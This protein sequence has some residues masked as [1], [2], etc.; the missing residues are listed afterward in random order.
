ME[1]AP[2]WG[3]PGP[4]GFAVP[5]GESALGQP[6]PVWVKAPPRAS[7]S[8]MAAEIDTALWLGCGWLR[9]GRGGDGGQAGHKRKAAHCH[10]GGP[11]VVV[12]HEAQFI[13]EAVACAPWAMV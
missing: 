13:A 5:Y 8:R 7:Y 12:P 6:Q 3:K 9:Y 1:V 10:L 2:A 11:Q 4:L